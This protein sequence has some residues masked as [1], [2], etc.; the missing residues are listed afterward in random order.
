MASQI[1]SLTI[2]STV[3]SGADLR[4]HQS[5]ASLAFVRGIHWWPVNSPHKWPLT[6]KVFPFD[7]VII[8]YTIGAAHLAAHL[9]TEAEYG[10]HLWNKILVCIF[11]LSLWFVLLILDLSVDMI[12]L[13][14]L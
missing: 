8:I 2:Y 10:Y 5:P 4:K 6:R 3:Y 14:V 12:Y 9:A 13:L 1:T 7:D 11:P